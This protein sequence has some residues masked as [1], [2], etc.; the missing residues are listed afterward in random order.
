MQDLITSSDYVSDSVRFTFY[1]LPKDA[2]KDVTV[3]VQ[4]VWRKERCMPRAPGPVNQDVGLQNT[5]FKGQF[6]T[7]NTSS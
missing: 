1:Q 2:I 5:C 3:E 6:R 4:K 7:K